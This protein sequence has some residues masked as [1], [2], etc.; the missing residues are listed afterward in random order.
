MTP[1]TPVAVPNHIHSDSQTGHTSFGITQLK[2]GFFA[3]MLTSISIVLCSCSSVIPVDQVDTFSKGEDIAR[4]RTA[5]ANQHGTNLSIARLPTIELKQTSPLAS[6]MQQI[7]NARVVLVGEAHTRWDHH[8]VQLEILKQLYQSNPDLAIGVEWFQ[9]PYQKH[10]DAYIAGEISEQEML[11]LTGYYERWGYDYR[12]YRPV[13]EYAREHKIPVIALNASHELTEAIS[14]SGFD[15]LPAELKQQLP[16]NYDWSDKEYE[17]FLRGIF[18]MHQDDSAKFEDFLRVQLT[19]DETMAESAVQHLDSNPETRMIIF[20]GS[21]HIMY[22]S[23]IPNR[24]KRRSDVKQV[25]ILVSEDHMPAS[26]KIA[27]FLVL[28]SEQTLEPTG[29]IGALLETRGKLLVIKGLL[30]NGAA[31]DAGM[32]EGAVITGVDNITIESFADFRLA[33]MDKKPGDSIVIRYL[34]NAE[35]GNKDIR[36]VIIELR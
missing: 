19:W 23:G 30:D 33:V 12:L 22:G 36:T 1:A 13:L 4:D 2:P 11:R 18:D 7:D 20:A 5:D 26:E 15:E 17:K 32:T 14:T 3:T 28:S 35:A 31:K 21:G 10:L 6:V 9:R 25:S 29:R 24:I 8:Q 27:D 34:D 16:G